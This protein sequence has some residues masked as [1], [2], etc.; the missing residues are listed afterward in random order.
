MHRDALGHPDADRPD[1]AV[2]PASGPCR[3]AGHPDAAAAVDPRGH[4]PE[5]GAGPDQGL[6]QGPDVGNDIDRVAESDDRVADQL[7]GTMP[8]DLAAPVDVDHRRARIAGRAV[9]R[10]GPLARGVH[11]LVLKEQAAVG[12]RA[13]AAPLMQPPLQVPAVQV[14]DCPGAEAGPGENQ[15]SVHADSLRGMAGFLVNL[16]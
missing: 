13:A 6:L 12:Y 9:E 1:L 10:A 5:V 2:R 11:R 16:R 3:A 14:T 15:L 7:A 4:H 8:G